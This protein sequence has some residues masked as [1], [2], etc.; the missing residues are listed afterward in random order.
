[1]QT[2]IY[3]QFCHVISSSNI[4]LELAIYPTCVAE[5]ISV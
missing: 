4:Y 5:T 3:L 2:I 1:M